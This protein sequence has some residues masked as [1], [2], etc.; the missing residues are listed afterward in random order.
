MLIILMLIQ[1]YT[2]W[3]RSTAIF[4]P[5]VIKHERMYLVS[6]IKFSSQMKGWA[7]LGSAR[8]RGSV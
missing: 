8:A 6:W 7:R 3:L 2:K 4:T 1:L 5:R